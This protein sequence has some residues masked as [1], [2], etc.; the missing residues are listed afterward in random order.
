MVLVDD[1]PE[2]QF[3]LYTDAISKISK[4]TYCFPVGCGFPYVPGRA[5]FKAQMRGCRSISDHPGVSL[6]KPHTGATEQSS[7]AQE[8]QYGRLSL[9]LPALTWGS[10][11]A[12]V[13]CTIGEDQG[14]INGFY[15]RGQ[16][17]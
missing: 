8:L 15:F 13:Y 1:L 6:R 2:D 11:E 12:C 9:Y 10:I 17:N 3:L 16:M 14:F 4:E 7:L 5:S